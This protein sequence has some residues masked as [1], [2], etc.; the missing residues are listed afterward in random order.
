MRVRRHLHL[1]D[2]LVLALDFSPRDVRL[3]PSVEVVHAHAG[4][5]DGDDDEDDGDDGEGCQRRASV[6]VLLALAVVLIHSDE[7][8]EEIGEGDEV[9]ELQG[10]HCQ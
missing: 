6:A 10:I 7:L 3:E 2:L 8:E 4:V 5:D 1:L 9:E